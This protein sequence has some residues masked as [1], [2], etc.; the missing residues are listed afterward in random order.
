MNELQQLAHDVRGFATEVRKLGYSVFS[1]RC[2]NDFLELSERMTRRVEGIDHQVNLS[3][4]PASLS[5]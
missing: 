5:R 4:A 1:S 2:E 3:P